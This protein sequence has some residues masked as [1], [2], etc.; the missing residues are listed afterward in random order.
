MPLSCKMCKKKF[1]HAQL[2]NCLMCFFKIFS[3]LVNFSLQFSFKLVATHPPFCLCAQNVGGTD[4][5]NEFCYSFSSHGGSLRPEFIL[6][7][8]VMNVWEKGSPQ[9]DR[10]ADSH[11]KKDVTVS[12]Q[13][14]SPACGSFSAGSSLIKC[15]AVL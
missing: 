7:Y 11:R 8:L 5:F 2:Q 6:I 13:S 9:R 1:R 12:S 14:L 4:H 15:T 3:S 10:F